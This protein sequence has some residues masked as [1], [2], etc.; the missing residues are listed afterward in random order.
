MTKIFNSLEE[1][2]KY[3]NKK[4]NTYVFKE[5]GEYIH[6][7]VCDFNLDVEANIDVLNIHASNIYTL[8]IEAS[9]IIAD[10][11]RARNITYYDLCFAT[12][13]IKCKSIEPKSI[14]AK[15]FVLEGTL[16]V[17]MSSKEAIKELYKERE[18]LLGDKV[19]SKSKTWHDDITHYDNINHCLL[20]IDTDLDRLEELEK[21]NEL[22]KKNLEQLETLKDNVE[23]GDV[24]HEANGHVMFS[25]EYLKMTTE[26][27]F[28]LLKEDY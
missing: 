19:H 11:I 23:T 27:N 26:E 13:S 8:D 24:V 6:L 15:H 21:E 9:I 4:T 14:N 17:G 16:Q 12:D 1:I 20:T 3:Y 10:N 25:G 22:L 18:Y 28:D 7:V 2:P 5:K